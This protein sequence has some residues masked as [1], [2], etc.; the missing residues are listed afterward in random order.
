MFR[1]GMR[2]MIGF[3]ALVALYCFLFRIGGV[4]AVAAPLIFAFLGTWL[5]TRSANQS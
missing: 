3:T 1:F 2:A 5:Q 4:M